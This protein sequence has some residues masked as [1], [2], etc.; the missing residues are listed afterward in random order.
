M[1]LSLRSSFSDSLLP[2][3]WVV[4]PPTRVSASE[5][6]DVGTSPPLTAAHRLAQITAKSLNMAPTGRNH[7]IQCRSLSRGAGEEGRSE[8][9]A[10]AHRARVQERRSLC[11]AA[12]GVRRDHRRA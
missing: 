6:A 10:D 2:A 7:E 12:A 5:T 1:N 11:R 9:M 3:A 4:H 8:P